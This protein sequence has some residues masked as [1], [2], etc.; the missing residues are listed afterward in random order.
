MLACGNGE[1]P[2]R[3]GSEEGSEE[4]GKARSLVREG[5]TRLCRFETRDRRRPV[6][7]F[8]GEAALLLRVGRRRSHDSPLYVPRGRDPDLRGRLLAKG[9]ANL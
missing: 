1:G 6:S 8:E 4:P 9:Q 7:Q 3:L 5:A 2:V